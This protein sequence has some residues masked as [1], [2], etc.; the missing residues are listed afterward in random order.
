MLAEAL[1][2]NNK[3]KALDLSSNSIGPSGAHFVGLM[4]RHQSM[5]V[6]G[7]N[8]GGGV[9]TL[10]L[11]DNN[12]RDAGVR[13]ISQA[14]E[15]SIIECLWIDGNCISA[16]G[17]AVMADALQRNSNLKR[18]HIHHNSFQSLSP[19][20]SCIF[21][22]QNLESV[23]DS[24]HTLKHVFLNC[25]YTYEWKELD[26]I[27]TLNRMGREEARRQKLAL[28]LTEN[29]AL[30]LQLELDQKLLPLLLAIL[31]LTDNISATFHVMRNMPSE[32]LFFQGINTESHAIK[33]FMDV[34]YLS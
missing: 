23:A 30:L 17:L 7:M 1:R 10:I 33:E 8:M 5:I 27:L 15:N 20:I 31:T 22:K 29:P 2:S 34:E 14:L 18:L 24:N 32:V 19:L 9:K 26:T 28:Y 6:D 25:G 4:L 3:L 11:S 13:S 12:L 16:N 21:N